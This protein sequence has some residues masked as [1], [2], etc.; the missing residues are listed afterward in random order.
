MFFKKK[1]L[2]KIK[3]ITIC[4]IATSMF[5]ASFFVSVPVTAYASTRS[6]TSEQQ[7]R[8]DT[9]ARVC[10]D[11]YKIYGILPSVCLAQAI[12]ESTMGDHCRGNNLWGIRA[13]ATQYPSLEEGTIAY[14][15]VINNGRYPN[16]PFCKN[17]Y[18]TISY[19]MA[20]GYCVPAGNYVQKATSIIND[21]DLTQYDKKM[22]E[23]W[24]K[25]KKEAKE[26]AL[27][28]KKAALQK[29]KEEER[30]RKELERKRRE[31]AKKKR[32]AEWSKLEESKKVQ[33]VYDSDIAEN[34]I[35]A[36]EDVASAGAICVYY[37]N[38]NLGTYTVV[39]DDSVNAVRINDM[40]VGGKKISLF[41]GTIPET[42]NERNE[43]LFEKEVMSGVQKIGD[44]LS[45]HL[46][47]E[48][49]VKTLDVNN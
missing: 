49:A 28:K 8:V 14:L 7:T 40:R 37:D 43:K 41:K 38:K 12:V 5:F 32:I 46:S 42:K 36:N 19:I 16:A 23:K 10:M 2:P 48:L 1:Y 15:E 18:Q 3:K 20:G 22:Y 30:R 25:E 21:Y 13:G 44:Y 31:E 35:V 24:E 34:I 9:V 39:N 4:V 47:A 29:K 27:R 11:N 26:K 6:F 45:A 33:A 17:P